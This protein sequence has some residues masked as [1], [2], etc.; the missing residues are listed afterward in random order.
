MLNSAGTWEI[1]ILHP[2]MELGIFRAEIEDQIAYRD[3]DD[4]AGGAKVKAAATV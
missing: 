2:W 1:L 3:R 4:R